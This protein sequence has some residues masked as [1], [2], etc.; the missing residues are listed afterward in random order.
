MKS[1]AVFLTSSLDKS[2]PNHQKKSKRAQQEPLN[3]KRV[4]VSASLSHPQP[5]SSFSLLPNRMSSRPLPPPPSP[6]SSSH[7]EPSIY[8]PSRTTQGQGAHGGEEEEDEEEARIQHPPRIASLLTSNALDDDG[9]G[10][11]ISSESD[12]VPKTEEEK[13]N[14]RKEEEELQRRARSLEHR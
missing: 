10:G 11:L 1:L 8:D 2:T 6:S 5:H 7:P 12:V 4:L 3:E 9:W 14:E 13:E